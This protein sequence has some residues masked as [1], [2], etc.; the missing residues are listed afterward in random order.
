MRRYGERA[1]LPTEKRHYPVLKH[2]IITHMFQQDADVRFV[3]D[4][5]GHSNIVST[6]RD[7]KAHKVF[8]KLPR[9]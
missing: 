6:T 1:K 8:L 2:S 9:F 3:Q 7:E 5:V 4:W